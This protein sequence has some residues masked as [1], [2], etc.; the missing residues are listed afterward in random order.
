MNYKKKRILILFVCFLGYWLSFFNRSLTTPTLPLLIKDWG[1]SMAGAGA[2]ASVMLIAYSFAHVPLGVLSDKYGRSRM[3]VFGTAIVG[4]VNVFIGYTSTFLSFLGLRALL[5]LGA[6][7]NHAPLLAL[8]NDWFPANRRGLAMSALS[9]VTTVGPLTCLLWGNFAIAKYGAWQPVYSLTAIPALIIVIL[10]MLI[11]RDPNAKE[12]DM[13]NDEEI[14]YKKAHGLVISP[15]VHEPLSLRTFLMSF[16]VKNLWVLYVSWFLVVSEFIILLHFLPTLLVRMRH[17][18]VAQAISIS[19]GWLWTG[20]FV[21]LLGGWLSDHYKNRKWFIFWMLL[22]AHFIIMSI[23]FLPVNMI[24]PALCVMGVFWFSTNGAFYAWS[25]E[26]SALTNP[27]LIATI[28]GICI[29]FGD[30]GGAVG[31]TVSG[32]LG[33]KFGT[34]S[35]FYLAGIVGLVANL[36]F[37]LLPETL[38]TKPK[39]AA[40]NSGTSM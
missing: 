9:I 27:A 15:R 7:A 26:L 31:A 30:L 23:P 4:I 34:P 36:G 3:L 24:F 13:I 11:V 5:G 17:L 18:P 20:L 40:E 37:I 12:L 28:L 10:V 8:V 6:A 14:E 38:T 35:M 16:K 2:I 19:T 33:D 32:Y 29:F 1:I 39:S 21:S 22:P 25:A